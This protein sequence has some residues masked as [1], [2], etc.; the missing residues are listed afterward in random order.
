MEPASRGTRP[1]ALRPLRTGRG[2]HR[3][4]VL[5]GLGCEERPRPRRDPAPAPRH[6]HGTQRRPA[7]GIVVAESRPVRAPGRPVDRSPA[8]V[9][10]D[11]GHRDAVVRPVGRHRVP[12]WCALGGANRSTAPGT[13]SGRCGSP[14]GW[15]SG[16]MFLL[17]R[18]RFGYGAALAVLLAG[19]FTFLSWLRYDYP[20]SGITPVP[21]LGRSRSS[22]RSPSPSR[23]IVAVTAGRTSPAS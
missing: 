19:L 23:R 12:G 16:T 3:F 11:L 1:A 10:A 8:A 6:R 14:A 9:P 18:T 21:V 17:G 15:A 13:S 4:P 7:A 22:R 20:D 5:Q 2:A